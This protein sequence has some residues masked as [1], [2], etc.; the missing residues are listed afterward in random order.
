VCVCV[1]VCSVCVGVMKVPYTWIRE[2]VCV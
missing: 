2:T 1:C